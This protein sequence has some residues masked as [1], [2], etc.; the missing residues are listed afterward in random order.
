MYFTQVFGW[1]TRSGMSQTIVRII[2]G[3]FVQESDAAQAC[4]DIPGVDDV[5][6]T[7]NCVEDIQVR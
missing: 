5:A 6:A 2:C 4:K 7:E 1:P 3:A